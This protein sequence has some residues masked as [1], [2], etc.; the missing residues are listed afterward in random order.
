MFAGYEE[1]LS[2]SPF[3]DRVWRCRSERAGTFLSI[4]AGHGEF[5]ITRLR[6]KTITVRGPE[7]TVRTLDYPTEAEWIGIRFKIGTFL[8]RLLPASLR[9]GRDVNLAAASTRSF[10]FNGSA[11]EYPSFENADT[12]IAWLARRGDIQRDPHVEATLRGEHSSRMSLRTVQRHVLRATG[13]TMGTF[14]QIE[15]ARHATNL[16]KEG[17][18]IL[19]VVR[20]AGYYDQAH[21]TRSLTHRIG[22]T[23]AQLQRGRLQ[24]S[25][26]LESARVSFPYKTRSPR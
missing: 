17:V 2:D 22:Q 20:L 24:L 18:P 1:R 21:L 13:L 6:S 25:M 12:F 9:D 19:D 14:H 10:W 23:P 4:A 7:T 3:V 26:N 5:V 11:I 15:R 8:P 16:L